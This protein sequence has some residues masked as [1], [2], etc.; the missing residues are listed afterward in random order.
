M[1][2][3]IEVLCLCAAACLAVPL[4]AAAADRAVVSCSVA[5][6]YS[7][8]GGTPELYRK[9][10]VVSDESPYF[11]DFS[12]ATRFREFAATVSKNGGDSVV[13]ID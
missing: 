1:S 10:F 4:N 12:S 13:T 9:D 3:A 5:I 7:L 11:D 8:S 6:D 2:R